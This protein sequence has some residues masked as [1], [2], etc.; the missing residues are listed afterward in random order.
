MMRVCIPISVQII[1]I[2]V[3]GKLRGLTLEWK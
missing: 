1:I 3:Q 2:K